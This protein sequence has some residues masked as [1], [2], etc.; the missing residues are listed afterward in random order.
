MVSRRSAVRFRE[1][2]LRN[3]QRE[4]G[5]RDREERQQGEA[6]VNPHEPGVTCPV[7]HGPAWPPL[8]AIARTPAVYS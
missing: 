1:G 3:D 2:A 5:N 4:D 6:G 8:V 7:T